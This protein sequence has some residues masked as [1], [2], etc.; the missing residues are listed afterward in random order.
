MAMQ[1]RVEGLKEIKQVLDRLPSQLQKNV[2]SSANRAGAQV[3][4]QEAII[5]L[6][7]RG[8]VDAQSKVIIK[9]SKYSTEEAPMVLVGNRNENYELGILERGSGAHE[10]EAIEVKRTRQEQ[11]GAKRK[12][13]RTGKKVLADV[14]KGL[15]F[16]TKVKHPGFLAKPW[17]RPAFDTKKADA[18][19][20]M[21]ETLQKG[22]E[23]E[24]RKLTGQ[25]KPRGRKL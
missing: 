16:G 23:R 10:I 3:I 21:A 25:L 8:V 9:K 7:G 6:S 22:I 11:A 12:T 1:V 18:V 13:K 15:F 24:V 14:G 17:L 19:K 20:K 2:L 4:R 5:A